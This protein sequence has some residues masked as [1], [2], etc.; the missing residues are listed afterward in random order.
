MSTAGRWVQ[1]ETANTTH[2]TKVPILS[3]MGWQ[4]HVRLQSA[5]RNLSLPGTLQEPSLCVSLQDVSSVSREADRTLWRTYY[6][7]RRS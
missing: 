7:P 5:E 4:G 6:E 1:Q 3:D 2:L